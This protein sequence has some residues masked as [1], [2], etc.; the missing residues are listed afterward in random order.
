MDTVTAVPNITR[1]VFDAGCS[2]RYVPASLH[3]L[4]PVE[5]IEPR[6]DVKPMAQRKFDFFV[7]HCQTSGQDQCGKL[8]ALL[9][10]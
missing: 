5:T 6:F 10:G 7:S 4:K 9:A 1:V 8:D 2:H 3:K